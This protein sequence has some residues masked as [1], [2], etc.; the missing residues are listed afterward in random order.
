MRKQKLRKTETLANPEDTDPSWAF[1]SVDGVKVTPQSFVGTHKTIQ[2]AHPNYIEIKYKAK[3]MLNTYALAADRK[4]FYILENAY[5]RN[6]PTC[7][8]FIPDNCCCPGDD[9]IEWN[10]FDRGLYNKEGYC[11]CTGC[12]GGEPTVFYDEVKCQCCCI[13]CYDSVTQFFGCNNTRL[14]GERIRYSPFDRCCCCIS[15]RYCWVCSCCGLFGPMNGQPIILCPVERC[16]ARNESLKLKNAMDTARLHW[17]DTIDHIMVKNIPKGP[18]QAVIKIHEQEEK[19]KYMADVA[20]AEEGTEDQ[21]PMPTSMMR[22]LTT[23]AKDV[24]GDAK[25]HVSGGQAVVPI[26]ALSPSKK[27]IKNNILTP[28][29]KVPNVINPRDP[30]DKYAVDVN[31]ATGFPGSSEERVN[32]TKMYHM[33]P[34]EEKKTNQALARAEKRQME[35]LEQM[36]KEVKGF[37]KEPETK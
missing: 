3:Y 19:K 29:Q 26:K 31:Q 23:K 21:I 33:W 17:Q 4:Y 35:R 5:T 24:I 11:W 25:V 8:Y 12:V 13:E 27:Q 20:A 16:L 7:C 14:C 18:T 30:L 9:T 6:T 22:D 28:E 32:A 10:F 2:T 1:D 37:K 34:Q 15:N 36:K